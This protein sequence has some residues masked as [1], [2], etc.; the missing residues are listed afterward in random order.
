[1]NA[2]AYSG[3]FESVKAILALYPES[4]RS[5]VVELR[6]KVYNMT[7]LHCAAHSSNLQLIKYILAL[8]PESERLRV[9]R[10]Q[11][12]VGWTVLHHVTRSG[13][14][15]LFK[16]VLATHPE[17][18]HFRAVNV[19]QSQ[20]GTTPLQIAAESKC[21]EMIQS[22]GYT[23]YGS[24]SISARKG[25]HIAHSSEFSELFDDW[26]DVKLVAD[27]FIC[28]DCYEYNPLRGNMTREV[29]PD[30]IMA[31]DDPEYRRKHAMYVLHVKLGIP[32][33][34]IQTHITP[35]LYN[36]CYDNC[37]EKN[38]EP[39]FDCPLCNIFEASE[40]SVELQRTRQKEKEEEREQ[41]KTKKSN[42]M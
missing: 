2:A 21:S 5:R 4:E 9:V 11:D 30:E 29:D 31:Q 24:A 42:P 40:Y 10:L 16:S 32:L 33:P 1:M 34:V 35:L 25:G 15:E 22:C 37:G 12:N 6:G 41:R 14:I 3:C 19:Q 23:S 27:G 39:R 8:I 28:F 18:E 17:S 26:G 38:A 7:V 20:R 36:C 13:N